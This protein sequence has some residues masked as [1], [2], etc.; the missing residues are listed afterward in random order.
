M[1]QTRHTLGGLVESIANQRLNLVGVGHAVMPSR[2]ICPRPAKPALS[3]RT[4]P[5][6]TGFWR[7]ARPRP[8]SSLRSDPAVA[9]PADLDADCAPRRSGQLREGWSSC[10][11]IDSVRA[12]FIVKSIDDRGARCYSAIASVATRQLLHVDRREALIRPTPQGKGDSSQTKTAHPQLMAARRA[13]AH[14]V[15]PLDVTNDARTLPSVA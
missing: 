14:E 1:A 3:G 4:Q 9:G 10:D 6:R 2:R 12:D 13:V 8:G 15:A 11:V 7:G 5:S